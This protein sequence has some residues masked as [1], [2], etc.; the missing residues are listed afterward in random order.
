[1][2]APVANSPGT[3]GRQPLSGHPPPGVFERVYRLLG[4]LDV[5]AALI[6]VVLSVAAIGSCLPELPPTTTAD[7]EQP[8]G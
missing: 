1:M 3:K 5:A 7:A 2:T 8:A 4:R 6:L